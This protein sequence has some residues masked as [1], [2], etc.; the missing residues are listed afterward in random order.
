[1]GALVGYRFTTNTAESAGC[2][3]SFSIVNDRLGGVKRLSGVD[4]CVCSGSKSLKESGGDVIDYL[5][6][7][8]TCLAP[9]AR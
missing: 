3:S 9:E 4:W 8:S 6:G 2:C 7:V 1:M 5:Y